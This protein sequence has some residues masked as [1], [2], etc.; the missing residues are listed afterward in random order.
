MRTIGYIPPKPQPLPAPPESPETENTG[1][2]PE[3][4]VSAEKPGKKPGKGAKQDG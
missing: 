1:N 3:E 2:A 4:T